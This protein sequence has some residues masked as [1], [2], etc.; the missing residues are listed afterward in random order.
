MQTCKL[1]V[2]LALVGSAGSLGLADEPSQEFALK[3]ADHKKIGKA[4]AA[5]W[6]A[7]GEK[8]GITAAFDKLSATVEKTRKKI[9]DGRDIFAAVE[10]W[11]QIFRYASTAALKDPKGKGRVMTVKV[12]DTPVGMLAYTYRVSRKYSTKRGPYPL[13]LIVPDE[14]ADPADHL[15]ADWDE[16][17]MRDRAIVV[18][19]HMEGADEDW[20]GQESV[21][22]VMSTFREVSKVFVLDY[23]RV[24][25][26]GVGKGFAAAAATA[27]GFPQLFA[28]VVGLGS[29]PEIDPVNFRNLPSLLMDAGEGGQSFHD[30]IEGYDYGNCTVSEGETSADTWAWIES[31][32]RDAYPQRISFA[33]GL[34]RA[35]QWLKVDGVNFE[36]NPFIDAVVDRDTNTITINANKIS[37]VEVMF[38]D[39]LVNMDEPVTVVVNGT[40]HEELMARNPRRMIDF[41]FD[42]GDWGRVF[43]NQKRFDVPVPSDG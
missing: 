8:K 43:T 10:D 36:E 41:A 39:A 17:A 35:A 6:D 42:Q 3:D 19:V 26:V 23:D 38:N 30:K 13:V 15:D 12:S 22:R 28:G 1:L 24:F 9:K 32:T 40:V 25:L 11:E 29:I 27:H 5:Y 14:G 33:P 20:T 34:A 2:A 7:K 31:H 37:I 21:Y 18:A 4:V 16:Q